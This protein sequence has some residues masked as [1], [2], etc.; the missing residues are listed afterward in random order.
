MRQIQEL[1]I[2]LLCAR[3]KAFEE[4]Y[5][6]ECR[7]GGQTP[8]FKVSRGTYVDWQTYDAFRL[9]NF[10]CEYVLTKELK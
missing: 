3:M 10:A 4:I 2:H 6:S 5:G 8:N 1:P 9:F 7:E